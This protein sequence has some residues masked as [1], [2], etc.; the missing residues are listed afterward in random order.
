MFWHIKSFYNGNIFTWVVDKIISIIL[1]LFLSLF[2]SSVP[3]YEL[4]AQYLLQNNANYLVYHMWKN[5]LI[6]PK[7]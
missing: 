7:N 3:P 1:N 2:P 6:D 5:Y 4:Q